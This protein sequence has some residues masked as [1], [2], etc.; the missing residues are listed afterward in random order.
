VKS[1]LLI[2]NPD[3]EDILGGSQFFSHT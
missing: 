3:V 2:T 1:P